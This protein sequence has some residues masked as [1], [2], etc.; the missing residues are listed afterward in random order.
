[1]TNGISTVGTVIERL[2]EL[3]TESVSVTVTLYAVV[4]PIPVLYRVI[5]EPEVSPE[6]VVETGEPIDQLITFELPDK[7]HEP[8]NVIRK[9]VPAAEVVHT[10]PT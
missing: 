1:M 7:E 2:V 9:S 10:P 8:V 3:P 4:V 6:P 5:D